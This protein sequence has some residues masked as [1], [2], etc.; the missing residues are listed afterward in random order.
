MGAFQRR[1]RI[2]GPSIAKGAL[3][4]GGIGAAG[5]AAAGYD[6]KDRKKTLRGALYG[7]LGG[8]MLGGTVGGLGVGAARKAGVEE[9]KWK[10][11][12]QRAKMRNKQRTADWRKKQDE[13]WDD[14]HRRWKTDWE[15]R[16]QARQKTWDDFRKQQAGGG[17][18]YRQAG[19]YQA[20]Q[21]VRDMWDD[22]PSQVRNKLRA[23]AR[24][25]KDPANPEA[26]RT[27][28]RAIFE[29]LMKKHNISGNIDDFIKHAAFHAGVLVAFAG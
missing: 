27:N 6:P 23:T 4:G 1:L 5:G 19:G 10:Q 11:G 26:A 12:W 14:W 2:Y 18:G 17:G 3:I 16:R 8:A 7:G 28:Y 15:Q 22:V 20:R 24:H 9:A 29:K 25:I 13:A 21:T